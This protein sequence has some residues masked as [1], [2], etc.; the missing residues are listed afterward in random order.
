M[1]VVIL[2]IRYPTTP[3]AQLARHTACVNALAWAPH[4]ACHIC[5]AGDDSQVRNLN[6]GIE[7]QCHKLATWCQPSLC[8]PLASL[9][10]QALIWDLSPLAQQTQA[11]EASAA[12]AAAVANPGAGSGA[13]AAA[14]A[15][16]A[17]AAAAAAAPAGSTLDPILAYGAGAEINQLQW[18]SAQPDWV[19]VSFANKTQILRV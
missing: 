9:P 13:A 4:S 1:Q 12:A 10:L 17:G 11:A 15:A 14:A 5:T 16:M 7:I 19:A 8:V 18:S 3:L 2:D 6:P